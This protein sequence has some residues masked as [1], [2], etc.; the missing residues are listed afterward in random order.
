M[1][2]VFILVHIGIHFLWIHT[3]EC[4]HTHTRTHIDSF[5]FAQNQ[6]N[7]NLYI[8]KLC[9]HFAGSVVTVA[10]VTSVAM[11]LCKIRYSFK[12]HQF[13]SVAQSCPTLCNPMNLRTPGLRVYHQLWE[14]TQ[15]HVHWVVDAIQPSHPPSSPSAPALNLP[16]HQGLFQWVSSLH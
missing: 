15:T 10:Y 12:V 6:V 3:H 4:I 14:S 13:S 1:F 16:Q 5:C 11:K 2:L 9:P 8:S 7:D